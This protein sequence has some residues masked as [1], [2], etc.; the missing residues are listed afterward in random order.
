MR[1]GI[2][3]PTNI[4]SQGKGKHNRKSEQKMNGL[5]VEEWGNG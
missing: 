4:V 2:N 5:F 1:A 3:H